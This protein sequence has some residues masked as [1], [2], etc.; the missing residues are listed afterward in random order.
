MFF[1]NFFFFFFFFV[2]FG[3]TNGIKS[4]R[5]EREGTRRRTFYT[6]WRV[7]FLCSSLDEFVSAGEW[8]I[9]KPYRN[10]RAINT[11]VARTLFHTTSII[12]VVPESSYSRE[13]AVLI[14]IQEFGKFSTKFSFWFFSN[15]E[16]M[17]DVR[18]REDSF[19]TSNDWNY[20]KM[21]KITGH[22]FTSI[23]F[24]LN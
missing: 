11:I 20:R 23:W 16:P 24:D 17:L 15:Y 6:G 8:L 5:S 21:I 4:I 14:E 2:F 18:I 3:Q 10:R 19:L 7:E 12:T 9:L 22:D 1:F 13:Y